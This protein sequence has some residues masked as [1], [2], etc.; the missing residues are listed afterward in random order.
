M[1]GHHVDDAPVGFRLRLAV[2][3]KA[4]LFR[5]EAQPTAEQ[6]VHH[7]ALYEPEA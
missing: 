1:S 5:Q 7:G 2:D 6:V 4:G 3:A